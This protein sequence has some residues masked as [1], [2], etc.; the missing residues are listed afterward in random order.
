MESKMNSTDHGNRFTDGWHVILLVFTVFL[1]S[2]LCVGVAAGKI[3]DWASAEDENETTIQEG[4]ASILSSADA[5]EQE[6][7][8]PGIGEKKS[9][10]AEL[11]LRADRFVNHLDRLWDR[12]IY[13]KAELSRI[14][15]V[16]TYLTTGEIASSQVICGIDGWMF[17]K[18]PNDGNSMA[19]FEG[20]NRYS[21]EELNEML[22]T[23]LAAQKK[24]E[25]SGIQFAILIPPNKEN[26]YSEYMPKQYNHAPLSS[27]DILIDCFKDAGVRICS[28]K[29]ELIDCRNNAQVYYSCDSHWNQLGGYI[30]VR[31]ALKEWGIDVPGLSERDIVSRPLKNCYHEGAADDL[32]RMA[33]L[34]AFF[35]NEKEYIVKGTQL[36]D[37]QKYE[38][39]QSQ[40]RLSVFLDEEAKLDNTV[41]LI[42][43]SFR[44]AMIPALCEIFSKVCVIHRS[45]F[46]SEMLHEVHPDYLL[47]EYVERYSSEVAEID[48]LF[49]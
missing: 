20:T 6:Q 19:D 5:G 22:R 45:S 29:T 10:P 48:F 11:I 43:D 44:T 40:G 34:L 21:E 18:S 30:G 33:G 26:V 28:P 2:L 3:L 36:P 17:Y 24:A 42:G 13:K 12:S 8:I 46:R 14:D 27:T 9:R 1:F 38:D 7:R 4:S 23:T 16:L 37:W 25:E 31:T 15:A 47:M 32:A 49:Q 39:E 35:D 41:M